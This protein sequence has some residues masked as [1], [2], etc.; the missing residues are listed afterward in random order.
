MTTLAVVSAFIAGFVFGAFVAKESE[1][2]KRE[3]LAKLKRAHE[4]GHEIAEPRVPVLFDWP[5]DVEVNKCD[6]QN[7]GAS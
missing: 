2:R 6:S 3:M 1:R 5:T 4:I 7:G